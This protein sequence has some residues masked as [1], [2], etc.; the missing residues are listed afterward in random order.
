MEEIG[1]IR[2]RNKLGISKACFNPKR[3]GWEYVDY[4]YHLKT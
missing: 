4:L 2:G 1:L 3:G